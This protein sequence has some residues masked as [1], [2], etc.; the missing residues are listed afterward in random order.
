MEPIK[1]S[2]KVT[3]KNIAQKT[4]EGLEDILSVTC[5]QEIQV[6]EALRSSSN[7][8]ELKDTDADT[9]VE[10]EFDG[11]YKRWV[12]AG[13]LAA[14]ASQDRKRS[15]STGILL[16]PGSFDTSRNRGA[17]GLVLKFLRVLDIDPVGDLSDAIASQLVEQLETRRIGKP[18]LFRCAD[19]SSLN[20]QEITSSHELDASKPILLFLHG[21]FSST[22]GSFGELW[23]SRQGYNASAYLQRLF[24]PYGNQVYALEHHTLTASPIQNALQVVRLL[25]PK[26]RLHLVSH[27]RGGLVG[28]LLCQGKLLRRTRE[29]AGK[30]VESDDLFTSEELKAFSTPER[31]ADHAALQELETLLKERQIRVER[32]ARVACPGRGTVLAS[33][34]LEDN[35][36]VMF[37]ILNFIPAP[38][39]QA[40]AEFVRMVLMAV[41][42]KRTNPQELPGLEAMIP[43]SPLVYLLNRPNVQLDSGLAVIAGNVKAASLLG[44][45]RE[46]VSERFFGEDNDYVVNTAGMYGGA[47]R[48]QGMRFY[49]DQRDDS[50]HFGYFR[51]AQVLERL[52]NALQRPDNDLRLLPLREETDGN[53]SRSASTANREKKSTVYFL[54]GFMGSTLAAG[55]N[56]VWLDMGALSW[57]DFTYLNMEQTGIK[58][59]GVLAAFR[60]LLDLLEEN[61]E[62]VA[63]AWDWRRSVLDAG[64]RFGEALE[65]VLDDARA[66][67]RQPVL[68]IL[69]HAAGGMVVQGMMVE[70]PGVWQ[71]LQHE[72]DFRCVLLATPLQGTYTA[73]QLLLGEHRL[74]R[75]LDMVDGQLPASDLLAAQFASYP[76]L[77][78]QL[79]L[80]F[81]EENRWFAPLG[82][83]FANWPARNLLPAALRVRKQLADVPLDADRFQYV[84]GRARLTPDALEADGQGWRLRASGE[85]DGVVLWDSCKTTLPQWYMPVEHGRMISHKDYLS[86]LVNLLDDGTT[87][88]LDQVPPQIGNTGSQWLPKI[89]AELFPDENELLAAALGYHTRQTLEEVRPQV[90]IRVLHG[91]LEYVAYPVVVG[92]YEGDSILS[93]E[94]VL[95]KRLNGRMSELLR[96]GLYPG[97]LGTSEIFL[98]APG[99]K[100]GGAIVVGLGEVGKLTTGDLT[101]TFMRAMM[102]YTLEVRATLEK[103]HENQQDDSDFIPVHVAS[104]LVGTVGGGSIGLADS[105]AAIFRAITRTNAA[106]GKTEGGVRLRLSVVE[107]IELFEDRAVEAAR[108]VQDM[109]LHPEFRNDF[110]VKNL[111]KTLPGKRRRVM[112]Q[113]PA[114]WWRRLQVEAGDDGLKYTALTDR[115]RAEMVLQATQRKLVDQFIERAVSSSHDDPDV[116][117]IL[118]ELLLPPAM[119]EQAP[120]AENL[121]LVLDA[122]AS[123]YP[124]ELLYNRLDLESQ[125]LAVRA[126]LLRQLAVGQF[127]GQVINPIDRSALVIGDP[128]TDGRFVPLPAARQEA[129]AVANLLEEGGFSQVVREIASSPQ[130]ILKALHTADY[131]L[132]HLAGH[133]VYQYKPDE[134]SD[135]L[136]SGMVLGDGIFLTPVEIGQMRKVPEFAFINCCHLAKMDKETAGDRSRLAASLAQ[137]LIRMGVRAVIAAGWAIN[138]DAAKVFSETC[139]SALLKGHTFG[140]AVLMARRE[141]WSQYPNSNTW[142]AYQCYGD[143]DYKLLSRKPNETDAD[144]L[145]DAWRFVAEVEVVAELQN[146]ISMA[147]TAQANDFPWL[148]E[149]LQQLHRAI[150]SE[151]LNHADILYALGRAYGKLEMFGKA[152]DAYRAAIESPESNYPVLLL[153]DRV[154]LQTAWALAW[155]LG[156]TSEIPDSQFAQSPQEFMDDSLKTLKLLDGLGNSQ[157]RLE[158]EGKFWKRQTMMQSG[159]ERVRALHMME[160]AYRRAH[161]FALEETGTLSAYAL[162]NWLTSRMIRYL[163]GHLKQLDR[164]ELKGWLDQ[165]TQIAEQ[166]D[167]TMPSFLTGIARAECALLHYLLG[168]RLAETE[169]V[170]RVVRLYEESVGRGAAPRQLRYM[171]EHVSFLRMMLEEQV[172]AEASPLKPVVVAL[173]DVEGQLST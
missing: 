166:S 67:N 73:V 69:A 99:R 49:L 124:W 165:V 98:N 40:L 152:L 107:F 102:N 13:D 96:L 44:H 118:F 106:L 10:L 141:T 151:W 94:A 156:K 3:G 125:P 7:A 108:L 93:A 19:T 18:G 41:A 58:P 164:Q 126:G 127:R 162:V 132:L 97:A 57:G 147:D 22:D 130:A 144:K 39:F 148:Q 90:E 109:V 85:G 31:Q 6:E 1:V 71:R 158:G 20:L 23:E 4:G 123:A 116:G 32:F 81:L 8:V 160:I 76:G 88:K 61:H 38:R 110:T 92:H 70:M 171:S 75:L 12:R 103:L 14:Q 119:K 56:P 161:E 52:I 2:G 143:P 157:N 46:W 140:R 111:M 68:R 48:V 100:P 172:Q 122:A 82:E 89:S 55:G 54:P 53:R 87:R 29:S 30:F 121:V 11:G 163:R 105:I 62:V 86:A 59:D 78:E 101:A 36:S 84:H 34:R 27:S 26:T 142:G 115:A 150:P 17:V 60:P 155:K 37:N 95:D 154:S 153:E 104:L 137:E 64:R 129:E 168:A 83:R 74:I 131:R 136:V 15:S 117:K 112:Y 128:P 80:A 139:Y 138:D 42:K 43:N 72:A 33:A 66:D 91:N 134:N 24:A 133:G 114:G 65:R 21:T 50:S 16:G 145:A 169:Q 51:D 28:E 35:L 47:Q 170:Q 120:N 149:R 173:A 113:E 45:F 25:L 135:L 77:L 167:R 159:E 9:L 63:F 146:L 5:R 79:P